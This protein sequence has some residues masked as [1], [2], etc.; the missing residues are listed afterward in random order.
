MKLLLKNAGILAWKDDQFDYI[1]GGFL[2]IDGDTIDYVG[3]DKPEAAY[4]SEKDMRG[5]L[6]IPGLINCHRRR[7]PDLR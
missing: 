4:D 5:K 1:P 7:R 3:A 2:G 6:L